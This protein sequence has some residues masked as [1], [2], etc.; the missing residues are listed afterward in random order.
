MFRYLV[1]RTDYGNTIVR[2]TPT[3][4][5]TI[6]NELE[7]FSDFVIP[8][9]QPLYLWRITGGTDVVPNTESNITDWLDVINPIDGNTQVTFADLTGYTAQTAID[10]AGK[11]NIVTGATGNVGEFD[12]SG[13]LIDSGFSI[14]QLTGNTNDRY[15]SGMT[16]VG[17]TLTL[18][19]TQGL[20]DLTV[21]IV[22][23]GASDGVVS[24]ATFSGVTLSLQRTQGLPD[25]TV[26]LSSLLTNVEAD[27]FYLS[28]QT[29]GNTIA[30]ADNA[31][32]IV[33]ISGQ[34]ASNDAD[35][36]YISGQ[37][38]SNDADIAYISGQTSNKLN[39]SDFNT[40]PGSN[41]TVISGVND[42]ISYLSGQTSNKLNTSDFNTYSGNTKIYIDSVAA[43]LDPKQSVR[44]AT[45]QALTGGTYIATGGTNGTGSF[46]GASTVIDG[47]TLANTNRVL[48]KDQADPKQNGI[49]VVISSG[50]WDRASDQ[51][52]SPSSE[53]S[54]GNFTFVETGSTLAAT[55]WVLGGDGLIA[56]N[57]D[58][59][60]WIQFNAGISYIGG[61][62]IN[63]TGNTISL[64][65][66]SVAGNNLSWSGTQ[67][68]VV[69]TGGTL[70]TEL[71][72]KLNISDFNTYSGAT[73][74]RLQGIE[75][76]VVYL[77]GQTSGNTV[78]IAGNAAD[79]IYLSGQTSGNSVSIADNA[80]DIVYLSGQTSGNT[81]AIAGNAADIVYLSGQTSQNYNSV[82]GYT[83]T[84]E[85]RISGIESDITYISGIT[86][87]KLDTSIFNAY[88][89]ATQANEL[90]LIK[91]G[92][93]DINT[94]IPQPIVWDS[95]VTSGVTYSWSGGSAIVINTTGEYEITYNIPF[96]HVGSNND[97]S[98]GGN[99]ILNNTTVLDNTATAAWTA[100]ANAIGSL[101]LPS[102]TISFTAGDRIDL[103]GFRAGL[104]GTS[105]TRPNSSIL[106]KKK[107]TLQ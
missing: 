64:D 78:A 47:I 82:T 98:L 24:G 71:N 10:I 89:G 40:Y 76:D 92:A 33:Y 2:E 41:A 12:V 28:G 17:S 1:Y 4:G 21:N 68:D 70:G 105:N 35:I 104:A 80:S 99:V 75:A 37:T 51:D 77:S 42:D 58:D 23:S 57:T 94:I 74:T 83:A 54:S 65:G 59:L 63:I 3:S 60:N 62:G 20:P 97:R 106:I 29:S 15:V 53:V 102:V 19:R 100:R 14:A 32:D 67:L 38:A 22:S 48:V 72:S 13:N 73:N 9:N 27:I 18:Q 25:V 91:T 79:I 55:G 85:T 45:T 96:G 86:D 90:F 84:T 5:S 8:A 56:L 6:G 44:V 49:Y 50:N 11:I 30:I 103:V 61:V 39:T 88:T 43:G 26:D 31:G 34:T 66:A 87:N 69:V 36:A 81:V 93:T 52:G 107:S 7:L 101:S 16:Y 46:T 95:A